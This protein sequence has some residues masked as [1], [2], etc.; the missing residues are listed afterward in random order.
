MSAIPHFDVVIVGAGSIGT[1]AAFYLAKAGIKVLVI[2]RV[3][4]VGQGS[5][6]KAIGGIRATHSDPAKARLCL[7]SIEIFKNWQATYGDDIE[8]YQ[9]G[10]CFVAYRPQEEAAL[11]D[12]AAK[13]RRLGLDIQWLASQA[14]LEIVPDL[15]PEN[16]IGGSFS[17]QDGNASPLL[18]THAFYTHAVNY[19]AQFHFNEIVTG[20]SI[21]SGSVTGISTDRMKYSADIIIN[22]AGAYAAETGAL[23]GCS[24]PV[25]PDSHESAIT[26]AVAHFLNPMVVDIRPA[27]GSS[28]FYFYQHF[29]GQIIFCIT[30]DP[31]IWGYDQ[32]ETS[33]FLPMVARRMVEVMPRLKNIRIRRTWRGL[34]P[35][36]PDGNPIIGWTPEIKGFLQ[37]VG[38]C[39]QGFMLGPGVGELIVRLVQDRMLPGDGEIL[40]ILS[41]QRAFGSMEILK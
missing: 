34:Y 5:N 27:P 14:L 18:A 38:M 21:E 2:D 12:V 1:P 19:G 8:W 39:G 7:R 40:S 32:N 15:N 3:P 33:S 16:L 29:T 28:N 35:M 25:R 11:K 10:Y 23:A 9:G 41:P 20:I 22:A 30:P 36:T 17:P 4:S 24:V 31:P 26:E 6:K 13:Q 37:A